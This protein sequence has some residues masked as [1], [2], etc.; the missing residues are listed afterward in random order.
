MFVNVRL[1][2]NTRQLHSTTP[3]AARALSLSLS[4]YLYLSFLNSKSQQRKSHDAVVARLSEKTNELNI[5]IAEMLHY[6]TLARELNTKMEAME[7]MAEHSSG[8]KMALSRRLED[9][10]VE[11]KEVR[12]VAARLAQQVVRANAMLQQTNAMLKKA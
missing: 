4:I 2:I 5:K 8:I 1:I 6:K 10:L 9:L 3:F 11:L 7:R 12:G